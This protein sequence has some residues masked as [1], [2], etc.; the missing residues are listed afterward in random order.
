MRLQQSE[1]IKGLQLLAYFGI[2]AGMTASEKAPKTPV[3]LT[4]TASLQKDKKERL[5]KAL[6][7]NLQRR[8]AAPSNDS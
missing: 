1:W 3:T 4:K 2:I 5:A 7:R 8:K 6:R